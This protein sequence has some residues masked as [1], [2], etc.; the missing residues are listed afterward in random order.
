M[1]LIKAI[2]L[3]LLTVTIITTGLFVLTI[4]PAWLSTMVSIIALVTIFTIFWYNI[5]DKE[6]KNE[7]D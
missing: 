5:S 1:K 2:L 7:E 3:S 4:V 6:D